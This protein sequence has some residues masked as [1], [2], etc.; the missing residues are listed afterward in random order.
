M[1]SR[2]TLSILCPLQALKSSITFFNVKDDT[3]LKIKVTEAVLV[4][5]G[6]D[7][8]GVLKLATHDIA[9]AQDFDE[10]AGQWLRNRSR[11]MFKGGGGGGVDWFQSKI[12]ILCICAPR[13]PL[14]QQL[15]EPT[16]MRTLSSISC[17][18]LFEQHSL[19]TCPWEK[20]LKHWNGSVCVQELLC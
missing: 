15:S 17:R 2:D 5:G 9:E 4:A 7:D 10:L 11:P 20:Q 12:V 13:P 6:G 19:H 1:R 16:S 18:S 8:L 3:I 14:K